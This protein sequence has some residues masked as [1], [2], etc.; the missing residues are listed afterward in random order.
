MPQGDLKGY[1]MKKEYDLQQQQRWCRQI[2]AG[3]GHVNSIGF[4][5]RDVAVRDI[6]CRGLIVSSNLFRTQRFL[7]L[8]N[9]CLSDCTILTLNQ[10]LTCRRVTSLSQQVW[11]PRWLTLA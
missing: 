1:L 6:T 10:L 4:V 8:L 9:Y 7:K 5:H 3:L 2:A 11:L